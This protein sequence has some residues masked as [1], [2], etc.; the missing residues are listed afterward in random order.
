MDTS[1]TVRKAVTEADKQKHRS[2]GRCFEC[3]KQG[4][5]ARNCPDRKI[6]ARTAAVT[7]IQEV[8]ETTKTLDL[9]DGA[10][11]A[12]HAFQLSDD[13]RDAFVKKVMMMG[14][15]MGFLEA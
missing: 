12:E 4:H 2:E 1:A 13:A 10:A 7:T 8:P 14:E 6:K 11:L 15:E 3:S 9:T 5:I